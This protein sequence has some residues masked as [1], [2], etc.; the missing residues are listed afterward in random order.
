MYL[1]IELISNKQIDIMKKI[2]YKGN[3]LEITL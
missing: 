2:D 1:K 3:V